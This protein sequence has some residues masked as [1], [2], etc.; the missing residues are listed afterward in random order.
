MAL[1]GMGSVNSV[2]PGDATDVGN[3][4]SSPLDQFGQPER[5]RQS[6]EDSKPKAELKRWDVEVYVNILRIGDINTK[7]ETFEAE[8]F[9]REMWV[10][11]NETALQSDRFT[12]TT[13]F[14]PLHDDGNGNGGTL[15]CG[16]S[17][18]L[19]CCASRLF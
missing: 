17:S 18:V 8:F 12:S 14:D 11:S 5:A 7:D 16:T 10:E 9:L 2:R 4:D 3:E 1:A 15:Q 13:P 6:N 19:T